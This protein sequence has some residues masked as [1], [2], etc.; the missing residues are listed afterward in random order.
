MSLYRPEFEAAL[1]KF[2]E[3][4][5]AMVKKGFSRPILVG[6]AAVEFYTA[7]AVNTGDF[8]FCTPIQPELEIEL[9]N[10]GFVRPRGPGSRRAAGSTL[11]SAS[12]SRWSA[13]LRSTAPS[14]PIDWF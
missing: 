2:A 7:S 4:S 11:S 1:N 6:G 9:Q 14:V 3:V 8:D 12:D 10:H 5:E 13:H